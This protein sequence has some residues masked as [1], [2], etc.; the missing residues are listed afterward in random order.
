MKGKSKQ[1]RNDFNESTE[2]PMDTL[3]MTPG[4]RRWSK[5]TE[6]GVGRGRKEKEE[7]RKK[8]GEKVL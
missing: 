7:E 8:E 2:S 5:Q 3:D 1:L 6:G 4:D